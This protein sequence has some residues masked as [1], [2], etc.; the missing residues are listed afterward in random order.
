MSLFLTNLEIPIVTTSLVAIT[1]D[2]GRF[3]NV[4]WII[5]SYL[6]GYVGMEPQIHHALDDLYLGTDVPRR[7]RNIRKTKRHIRTKAHAELVNIDFY[8]VLRGLWCIAELDTA[9]W[10][11][12]QALG[13]IQFADLVTASS[14]ALFRVLEVRVASHWLP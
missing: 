10:Q 14:F 13:R 2:F 4:G 5:S 8:S 1:N 12:Y 6:L 7:T 11:P 3:D 9:V